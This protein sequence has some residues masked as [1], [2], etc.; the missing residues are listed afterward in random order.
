[1]LT[2]RVRFEELTD[3]HVRQAL[4]EGRAIIIVE[5]GSAL[6]NRVAAT[7]ATYFDSDPESP[8]RRLQ[9]PFEVS[10][11]KSKPSNFQLRFQEVTAWV[12]RIKRKKP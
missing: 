11:A 9:R 1:M 8:G 2:D 7:G 4:R 12:D 5:N 6:W 3:E 10:V